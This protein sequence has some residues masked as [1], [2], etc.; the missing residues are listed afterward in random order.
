MDKMPRGEDAPRQF[1]V[2]LPGDPSIVYT[3]SRHQLSDIQK[4]FAHTMDLVQ[5]ITGG[6]GPLIQEQNTQ[7]QTGQFKR[8]N[9]DSS[10]AGEEPPSLRPSSATSASASIRSIGCKDAATA[11]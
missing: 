11:R 8:R 10:N 5:G 6:S 9:S 3:L 1:G 2:P 7:Y 4:R